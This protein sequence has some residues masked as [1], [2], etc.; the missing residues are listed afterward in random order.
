MIKDIPSCMQSYLRLTW[1]RV[2]V[3]RSKN[4]GD[5]ILNYAPS[6]LNLL[7]IDKC[8][9][10]C[11]MCGHD[12]KNC[13]SSVSLTREK[14]K[15]IYSKLD[16]KQL[17]EVVYGG[18]GE[19]FLNP[20]LADIAEYTRKM[21]PPV[22]HT[23]ISNMVMACDQD[24]I[25]R[26]FKNRVH[27][28]ISVNAA[29]SK[30]FKEVAGLD[31]FEQVCNNLRN[32][33]ALKR[34]MKSTAGISISIILMR[35]NIA[36]L[37]NFIRLAKELGVDGVKAM[38]VRIYPD[39]YRQKGDG[40]IQIQPQDSLFFHQEES[41]ARMREA[42]QVARDLQIRF[43]HQP[44]FGYSK[45]KERHCLEPWRSL[46]I[47]FNGEL[48]PCAA[49]EI[50]FMHKVASGEYDSGNILKESLEEIWNNP[51]WQALRA[52]N[53]QKNR[54]VLVPECTCCGSSIDW[55]GVDE[56]RAHIM[57]WTNAEKA[58]SLF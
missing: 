11:I 15:I 56:I 28:L 57:D 32:I 16:M 9:S 34:K 10:S 50:L 6:S 20:E 37:P 25:T 4:R 21:C 44:I 49:S 8:N 36:D 26:L 13:G 29:T 24:V 19:P 5:V 55:W 17:V 23:V 22:Q 2:Q 27:F 33:V 51:F 30:T 58:E 7:M 48:Y 52:T 31:A 39:K 46:Y 1:G 12:Y 43:E 42:E 18:G 14:I 38:Y 41:N 54:D 47:G 40:S 35:Q 53:C 3:S 45:K